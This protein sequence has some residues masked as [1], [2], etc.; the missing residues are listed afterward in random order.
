MHL[1]E[2]TEQK[3]NVCVLSNQA[4]GNAALGGGRRGRPAAAA[5]GVTVAGRLQSAWV[6]T[7]QLVAGKNLRE[8]AGGVFFLHFSSKKVP[9]PRQQ[10]RLDGVMENLGARS[11]SNPECTEMQTL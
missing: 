9:P 4:G 7:K 3:I 8:L 2:T 5:A 11:S 6:L 1:A 10:N